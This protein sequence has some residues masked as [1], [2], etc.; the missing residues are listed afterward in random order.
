MDITYYIYIKLKLIKRYQ[1]RRFQKTLNFI[2]AVEGRNYKIHYDQLI[3]MYRK[4]IIPIL[5]KQDFVTVSTILKSK[6]E[7][8]F[9]LYCFLTLLQN[10]QMEQNPIN[11]IA[12][13]Q[14]SE[15]HKKY[16][17]RILY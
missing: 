16:G 10:C 4:T 15:F 5:L 1:N 2:K 6:Y 9:N 14:C 13:I 12:G 8:F 11:H 3:N 7:Q 17:I